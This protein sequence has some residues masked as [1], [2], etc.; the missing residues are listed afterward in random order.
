MLL[1]VLFATVLS[2]M[3][4]LGLFSLT[5]S[6]LV[7]NA[8]NLEMTV[9]HTHLRSV[10]G[11]W[12]QAE[13]LGQDVQLGDRLCEIPQPWLQDWC[14]DWT[15]IR[16]DW[17]IDGTLCVKENHDKIIAMIRLHNGV[18]LDKEGPSLQHQWSSL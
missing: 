1:D 3:I 14:D 2:T 15:Q 18:F 4:F 8:S 6:V 13:F 17:S 5:E 12:R 10:E 16:R 9:S 11:Y 7:T